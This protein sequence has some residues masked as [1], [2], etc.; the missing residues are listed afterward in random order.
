M[1]IFGNDFLIKTEQKLDLLESERQIMESPP[2][3]EGVPSLLKGYRS[4]YQVNS[5]V[6]PQL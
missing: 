5:L 3:M 6:H 2:T 4:S 1:L